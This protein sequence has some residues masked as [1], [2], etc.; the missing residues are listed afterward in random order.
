M[1]ERLLI[2][3][4]DRDDDVGRK[5]GVKTPIVGYTKVLNLAKNFAMIDPEDSDVNAIF[6]ALKTYKELKEKGYDA[7]IAVIAGDER[8]GAIADNKIAKELEEVLEVT[9]CKEVFLVSDGA[10]DEEILPILTSRVQVNGVQRIVIKQAPGIETTYYMIKRFLEDEKIQKKFLFP[11]G[12]VLLLYGILTLLGLSSYVWAIIVL[13]LSFYIFIKIYKL[14]DKLKAAAEFVKRQMTTGHIQL[15]FNLVAIIVALGGALQVY[16]STKMGSNLMVYILDILRGWAW[17]IYVSVLIFIS[18]RIIDA[19]VLRERL[20]FL[21]I[22]NKVLMSLIAYLLIFAFLWGLR[23][24]IVLESVVKAITNPLFILYLV[25]AISLVILRLFL[26]RWL[27]GLDKLRRPGGISEADP[28]RG[29]TGKG[30]SSKDA[31]RQ[32]VL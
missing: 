30:E 26:F 18:G 13:T 9:G 21:G 32:K 15:V 3:V 6:G 8:L 7:E 12:L 10:E 11:F 17:W 19:L 24:T 14:E 25:S 28:E 5:V 2:L 1:D 23:E 22:L 4:V 29:E 20:D 27:Y 16:T 31:Q